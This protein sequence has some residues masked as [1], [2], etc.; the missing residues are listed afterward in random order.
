[1]KFFNPPHEVR[2]KAKLQSMIDTLR[3]GGQLPP[4]V[5]YQGQAY[6]GSHRIAAWDACEM[7]RQA[8]ELTD[9]EFVLSMALMSGVNDLDLNDPD[10]MEFYH[11]HLEQEIYD[12]DAFLEAILKVSKNTAILDAAKDQIA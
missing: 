10:D 9:K 6:T 5:T 11:K 4:V 8:V 2:D 3:S 1:M 12:Y 7:D